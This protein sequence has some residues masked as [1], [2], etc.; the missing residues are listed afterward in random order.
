MDGKRAGRT[1]GL[2]EAFAKAQALLSPS[3][4]ARALSAPASSCFNLVR[5]FTNHTEV[6]EGITLN[7]L[8]EGGS[9]GRSLDY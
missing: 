3:E 5:A 4:L 9:N 2:F 8:Q 1:I 6:G 7:D